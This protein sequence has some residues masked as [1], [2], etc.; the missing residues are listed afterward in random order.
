M[1]V[2]TA[3]LPMA[4]WVLQVY[5]AQPYTGITR[6]VQNADGLI[7]KHLE[8]W[9]TSIADVFISALG[10]CPSRGCMSLAMTL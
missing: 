7:A 5:V 4:D 10:P 8:T 1:Q 9:D 3:N 2:H 6:Y